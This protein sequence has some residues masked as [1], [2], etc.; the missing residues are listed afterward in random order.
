MGVIT[1][2]A[3]FRD[4]LVSVDEVTADIDAYRARVT[5]SASGLV[6]NAEAE[7]GAIL[8]EGRGLELFRGK[9]ILDQFFARAALSGQFSKASFKIQL[10]RE[11]SR[12]VRLKRL[13]TDAVARIKFFL[14]RELLSDLESIPEHIPGTDDV[15]ASAHLARAA[16]EGGSTDG[17]DMDALRG[18]IR[19]IVGQLDLS[20][21]V[22]LSTRL[23]SKIPLIGLGS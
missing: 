17:I 19:D 5:D 11:A 22:E 10:A 9:Q 18:Q 2:R 14:P 15:L 13:T 20:G 23:R 12:H 8:R 3:R 21:H 1:T 16:M 6:E 7:V 4:G